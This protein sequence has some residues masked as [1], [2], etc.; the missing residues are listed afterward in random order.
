MEEIRQVSCVT[1]DYKGQRQ[2]RNLSYLVSHDPETGLVCW[3][4]APNQDCFGNGALELPHLRAVALGGGTGLPVVLKALKRLI[5]G[6]G[7]RDA[8]TASTNGHGSLTG[9]VT[10]TDDGGS[11][12]RLRR[13]FKVLPPG[14]VRNCIL[15]LSQDESIM[16]ELLAY[17][18]NSQGDL[19]GHSLGNLV[20]TALSDIQGSFVKAVETCSRILAIKGQVFP[21]TLAN[22]TLRAE[23][24]DGRTVFGE[25]EIALSGIRTKRVYLEPQNAEAFPPSLEE[26]EQ[27]DVIIIG[28]GS[29]Y[30]SLIPNLLVKGMAGALLK[31]RGLKVLVANLMTQSGETDGYT[32]SDHLQAIEENVGARVVD[33]VIVN[34]API[35]ETTLERYRAESAEP[36]RYSLDELRKINLQWVEE[37]L[38]AA[39]EPVRHDPDKLARCLGNLLTERGLAHP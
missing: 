34:N 7:S 31:A 11:S 15:S 1:E 20:L 2:V 8:Q 32:L 3:R 24:E 27:A 26:I 4:L 16:A 39:G 18:F 9:I 23:L 12:G 21:S 33:L 22:V 17:R 10:V 38:L 36:V 6:H 14:D 28:P 35:A 13:D 30:T 25:S 37:D 29:L 5:F 19:S